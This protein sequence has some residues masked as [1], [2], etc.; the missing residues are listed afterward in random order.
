M[1]KTLSL[2][3]VALAA[4]AAAAP[5][6]YRVTQSVGSLGLGQPSILD[7]YLFLDFQLTDGKGVGDGNSSV[8]ISNLG[9]SGGSIAYDDRRLPDLGNVAGTG[10][11]FTLRDGPSS[12]FADRAVLFRV[13]DATATLTYDFTVDSTGLDA[14]TPDGFNV[15][16]LYRTGSGVTDFNVV[17]TLGPTANEMVGYAFDGTATFPR[18]YGVDPAFAADR[19]AAGDRRFGGLGVPVVA[20]A[21]VPEPASLAAVGACLLCLR[22]RR[23]RA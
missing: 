17:P 1:K 19:A 4:L 11:A 3:F 8:V 13:A 22:R 10:N 6:T 9:L 14:P 5:L 7:P 2:A 16:L 20:L 21:P 12:G 23:R 15:A 18:G